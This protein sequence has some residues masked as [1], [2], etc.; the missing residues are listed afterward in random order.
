MAKA[1][2]TMAYDDGSVKPTTLTLSGGDTLPG[3]LAGEFGMY[4]G[5][6]FLA[7]Q[8]AESAPDGFEWTVL[9]PLA[10][11]KGA[12]QAATPQ[13]LS[14]SIDSKNVDRATQ[15]IN[16]FLSGENAAKLALGDVLVP[17]SSQGQE[18]LAKMT[19]GQPGW[20]GIAASGA[21]LVPAPFTNAANLTQWKDQYGQPA[22]KSYLADQ[23]TIDELKAKLTDGWNQIR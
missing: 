2:H 16:Y 8:I 18:A 19:E 22:F 3:F 7:A 10:G 13:T 12:L 9:P 4:I 15:F 23:I 11:S 5:G 20:E 6:T 21:T 14:V 17:A 1:V